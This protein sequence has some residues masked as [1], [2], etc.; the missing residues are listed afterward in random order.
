MR[1]HLRKLPL[2]VKCR[3]LFSKFCVKDLQGR[4]RFFRKKSGNTV[5]EAKVAAVV[6]PFIQKG[7]PGMLGHGSY[8][9]QGFYSKSNLF[10][11][12]EECAV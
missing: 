2:P 9:R 12:S 1:P 4:L 10:F 6:A 5:G 11:D 3:G 8:V 7:R